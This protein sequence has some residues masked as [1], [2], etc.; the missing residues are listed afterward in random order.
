MTLH[1][2]KLC[3]GVDSVEQ[4][5]SYIEQRQIL[6][7]AQGVSDEQIHTTRMV[8]TRTAELLEG[9]SLYWVI[10]GHVQARQK[11]VDI[12]PFKDDDGT[13]RCH[14]VMDPFLIPTQMQ[15]RRAFQGWRYLKPSDAPADITISAARS[16]I[17]A[18]MRA[19]LQ[20][21]CLI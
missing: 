21:L 14:I 3:V 6:A 9:G 13:K 5:Q 15:P 2:V 8:P 7:L 1:L 20:E 11:I 18:A 12:R 17:P 16:D 4:L 10:K 19:E